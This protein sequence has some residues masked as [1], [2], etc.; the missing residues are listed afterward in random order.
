M[1]SGNRVISLN[2]AAAMG[3]PVVAT[4]TGCADWP[5]R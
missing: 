2:G 3:R 1:G 4:L 5:S